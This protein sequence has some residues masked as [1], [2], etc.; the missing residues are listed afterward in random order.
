MRFA[1]VACG[2]TAVVVAGLA[3]L[4]S[5]AVLQAYNAI[6]ALARRGFKASA[7]KNVLETGLYV[8]TSGYMGVGLWRSIERTPAS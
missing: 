6:P 1:A 2:V 5:L 8:L 3:L 4:Y 7:A